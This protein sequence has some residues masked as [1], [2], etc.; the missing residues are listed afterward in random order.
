MYFN[1]KSK[2]ERVIFDGFEVIF[3]FHINEILSDTTDGFGDGF[4]GVVDYE[5]VCQVLFGH[6]VGLLSDY[7]CE[8]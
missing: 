7:F 8:W 1:K 5:K 3:D 4:C 2:R 6:W